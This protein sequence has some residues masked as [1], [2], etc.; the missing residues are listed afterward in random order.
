MKERSLNK[1]AKHLD[2]KL[3]TKTLPLIILNSIPVNQF[4]TF[5]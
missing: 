3:S 5:M 1:L 4:H 2:D